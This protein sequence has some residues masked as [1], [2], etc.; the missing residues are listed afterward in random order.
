[1][2]LCFKLAPIVCSALIHSTLLSSWLL[3]QVWNIKN[4]QPLYI[5]NRENP[6]NSEPQ[7]DP[8]SG[9]DYIALPKYDAKHW[10]NVKVIMDVPVAIK[11]TG[12]KEWVALFVCLL[13]VS[14]TTVVAPNKSIDLVSDYHCQLQKRPFKIWILGY[15]SKLKAYA[16][17]KLWNMWKI[18]CLKNW[19]SCKERFS[20]LNPSLFNKQHF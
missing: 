8:R 5:F 14:R 4:T 11:K 13:N 9:F 2:F 6:Q 18:F 3:E 17:S 7:N 1:M 20:E 10:A 12:K 16:A 15:A 19:Q